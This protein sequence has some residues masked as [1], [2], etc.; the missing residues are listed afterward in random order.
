LREVSRL[1]VFE[2]R[3]LR[4]L[5]GPR[6]DEVTGRWR[7]LHNKELNNLYTPPNIVRAIKSRIMR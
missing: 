2:N 4:R 6:R 5:F 7:K 1:R 3:I